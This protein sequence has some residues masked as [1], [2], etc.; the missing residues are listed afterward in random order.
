MI[1][2]PIQTL[3]SIAGKLAHNKLADQAGL[4][5]LGKYDNSYGPPA[6]ITAGTDHAVL[7][8]AGAY[9]G[10]GQV[11]L[12]QSA[13]VTGALAVANGGTGATS[14]SA[15]RTALGLAIGSNVQAY[16]A[17]LAA[18]AGL[19]TNGPVVRTGTAAYTTRLIQ[20]GPNIDVT[21]GSMVSGNTVI[22]LS[23]TYPG[24][25]SIGSVGTIGSGVWN[26]TGILPAYG[27]TGMTT[28][29]LATG[30][31][32]TTESDVPISTSNRTSISTLYFTP[33][34]NNF[35]SLYDGTNWVPYTF[36]QLSLA[37]G[38]K[39]SGGIYDVFVYLS[40]GVP[41]LFFGPAWTSGTDRG[42]GAGTTQI[43]YQNGRL[44]N[45]VNLSGGPNASRGLYV[46]SFCMV[47][48]TTTE[49][50]QTKRY[51]YNYHNQVARYCEDSDAT[52]HT[53]NSGPMANARPWNNT[54][55]TIKIDF[56]MGF[57]TQMVVSFESTWTGQY[58][59][60]G[61]D[62]TSTMSYIMLNGS[63]GVYPFCMCNAIPLQPLLGKHY[64][65][66]LELNLTASPTSMTWYS[67]AM[68]GWIMC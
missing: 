38:T 23:A 30:G 2:S 46:G 16:S 68:R 44:V 67:A 15:A 48:T 63:N 5:V 60:L 21:N 57:T 32:L 62:S 40:N 19:G 27:G 28:L 50:S 26:G 56:L 8:R 39:T 33:Y 6:D 45:G 51:V 13:A 54:A 31:R 10:F 29:G 42:T 24:Q 43:T 66:L 55:G 14:E 61:L 17:E 59:G 11:A 18:L 3:Y 53:H 58:V 37:V 36:S 12:N 20:A 25:S 65:E 64:L 52:N 7:R 34:I 1:V 9:I 47:N 35:V 41:T 49:D 4:S 22:S